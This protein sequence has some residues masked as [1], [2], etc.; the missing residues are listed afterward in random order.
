MIIKE[1][2]ITNASGES[3]EFGRHFR[4][5]EDINLSGLKADVSYSESANDGSSYQRTRLDVRDI[6]VP[7]FINRTVEGNEWIEERRQEAYRVLNPKKNPMRLDFTT[8]SG[9][10]YFLNAELTASPDFPTGFENSNYRWQKSLLQFTCSDPYLYEKDETLVQIATWIP[11]F[12]F[13]LEIPTD[14]IEMGYRSP[15]L[16]A[17]VFNGGQEDS[18]MIIKFKANGTLSTPS[19]VNV[20]TYEEFKLNMDLVGGDIVEVSTYKGKKYAYLTRNNIKISV[21][22]K[23]DLDSKFL[24]LETGDNLFRYD[25]KSGVDNLEVSMYFANKFV[26]V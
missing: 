9:E 24:Q 16:I 20:N 5:Y 18:G 22:G 4:L 8:K 13:A 19:L 12:E 2:K 10:S 23:V 26:G 3:I 1:L 15:S 14:G 17:N 7:F 21:F 6:N 25:A 11:A